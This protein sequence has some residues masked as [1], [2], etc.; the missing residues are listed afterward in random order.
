MSA[1]VVADVAAELRM[2]AGPLDRGSSPDPGSDETKVW[3]ATAG[4]A[5]S[6]RPDR[7]AL[8][9]NAKLDTGKLR[10]ETCEREAT[11]LLTGKIAAIDTEDATGR[12]I[13]GVGVAVTEGAPETRKTGGN[14]RVTVDARTPNPEEVCAVTIEL[15]RTER[16][17]MAGEM[18]GSALPV[19]DFRNTTDRPLAPHACKLFPLHGVWQKLS[20]VSVAAKA[21]VLPHLQVEPIV[22]AAY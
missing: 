10:G 11:A 2:T 14:S 21:N 5:T 1:I 7:K 3:R 13:K 18:T 20:G 6:D 22:M 19:L 12:A 15:L 4:E 16:E 8:D 17:D 9:G